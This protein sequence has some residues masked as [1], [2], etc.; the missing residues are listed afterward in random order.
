V[1]YRRNLHFTGRDDLLDQ[2]EKHLSPV[3]QGDSGITRRAALTQT[4]AIKGLGG[5]GKTQIAVEYAYRSRDLARYTHTLWVNAAN[6]E[7]LI[8]SFAALAELPPEF[9]AKD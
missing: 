3:G 9:P 6:E 7:T 8:P 4:Q 1:P 5:I 2:L